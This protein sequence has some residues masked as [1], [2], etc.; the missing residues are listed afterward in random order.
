[1]LRRLAVTLVLFFAGCNSFNHTT[2]EVPSTNTKTTHTVTV[3]G[4]KETV[5]DLHVDPKIVKTPPNVQEGVRT[6]PPKGWCP[7]YQLPKLP[8]EPAVPEDKLK[9]LNPKDVNAVEALSAAHIVDLHNY[10]RRTQEM[11]DASYRTYQEQCVSAKKRIK[12]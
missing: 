12:M 1:M 6:V 3:N 11:L 2:Y 10:I 4:M 5:P 9:A 8:P 7:T